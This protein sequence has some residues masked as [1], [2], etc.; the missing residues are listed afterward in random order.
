MTQSETE[1]L[2]ES[3]AKAN[4]QLVMFLAAQFLAGAWWAAGVSKDIEYLKKSEANRTQVIAEY[5]AT[6]Y[7]DRDATRDLASI[8]R[9]LDKLG[10]RLEYL[11]RTFGEKK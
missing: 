1:E 10:K 3:F 6:R 9:E 11:E 2:K 7:T 5:M 4:W 8:N